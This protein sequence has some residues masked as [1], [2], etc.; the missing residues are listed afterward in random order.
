[1]SE[2]QPAHIASVFALP[3]VHYRGYLCFFIF[4]IGFFIS[5]F[6]INWVFLLHW[7]GIATQ[8]EIAFTTVE[9]P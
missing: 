3:E 9:M 7:D 1:M 2:V 4:F 8:E 6:V 5:V